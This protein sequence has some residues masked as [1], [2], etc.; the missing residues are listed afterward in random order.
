MFILSYSSKSL[1]LSFGCCLCGVGFSILFFQPK[2]ILLIANDSS[3]SITSSGNIDPNV[4]ME[5]NKKW[6]KS[7]GKAYANSSSHYLLACNI[8]LV[9][10]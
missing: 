9:D 8:M 6:I 10:T 1:Q 4:N 3:N 5:E 2:L 7:K